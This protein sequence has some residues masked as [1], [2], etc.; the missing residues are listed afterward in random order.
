MLLLKHLEARPSSIH[1]LGLFT[2]APIKKGTLV[3]GWR[4]EKDFR[5]SQTEWAALPQNLRDFLYTYCW[6]GSDGLWYGTHD[7]ARFTNCSKDP[8]V[9]WSEKEK[10]MVANRNIAAGEE[11]TEDYEEYDCH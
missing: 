3:T 5:L 9:S 6:V 11:I 8:N 1:G 4:A 2:T 10:S 7:A